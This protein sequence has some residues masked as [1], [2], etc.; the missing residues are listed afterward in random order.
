MDEEFREIEKIHAVIEPCPTYLH[1]F[2]LIKDL[3]IWRVVSSAEYRIEAVDE[4]RGWFII[5]LANYG[6]H[7]KGTTFLDAKKV[8]Y[9]TYRFVA[10][11]EHH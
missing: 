11:E 8:V 9:A 2:L 7:V 5:P 10:S 6:K 1:A 3:R 4:P